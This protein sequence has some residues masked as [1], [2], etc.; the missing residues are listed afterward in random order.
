MKA[1]SAF[2]SRV[3]TLVPGSPDPTIEQAVRDTA[4]EF[5]SRTRIIQTVETQ[6]LAAEV[7]DYEVFTP[8]QQTL[9]AVLAVSY[10][11]EPLGVTALENVTD[12]AAMRA[13][14][15]KVV[16]VALG[17][18][19]SYYQITPSD[20]SVYLWPVP[21][22]SE[23]NVLAIRACFEPSITCT[24]LPDELFNDWLDAI[25]HGAAARLML[26]PNMTVMD[27]ELGQRYRGV[28][29]GAVASASALARRGRSQAS[30]Y[31]RP[32]RFA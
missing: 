9:T 22:V 10:R 23:S 11:G 19:R 26:R 31:V 5:C 25:V 13:G 32:R 17:T 2:T 7:P 14:T 21:A 3:A 4:I 6:S 1:L 24:Q 15:D 28:F 8:P 29:D 20:T 16:P 30:L 27:M 12:G 18:P